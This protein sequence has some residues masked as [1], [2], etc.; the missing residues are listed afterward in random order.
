MTDARTIA[1]IGAGNGGFNL[2][3]AETQ[4]QAREAADL[5]RVS[6]EALPCG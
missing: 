3:V 1:I 6:Y 5:V 2:V 4:T